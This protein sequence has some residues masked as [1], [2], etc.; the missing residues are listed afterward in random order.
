[1]A[2]TK[3]T[4]NLFGKEIHVTEVPI[5]ERREVPAEYS[6]EDGSVVRFAT[7]ATAVYRIDDQYDP[8]GN[9]IY[10]IKNGNVVTVMKA[11]ANT[12]KRLE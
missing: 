1:V 8:E 7:V 11:G 3:T 4:L 9:P 12:R 10:I 6:L 5:A 2:E